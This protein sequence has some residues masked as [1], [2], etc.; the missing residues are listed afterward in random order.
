MWDFA[1]FRARLF[2]Q[3]N[4]T[5]KMLTQHTATSWI[6]SSFFPKATVLRKLDINCSKEIHRQTPKAFL[7][8]I[9]FPKLPLNVI[10]ISIFNKS[11]KDYQKATSLVLRFFVMET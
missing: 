5:E 1:K 2:T 4:T 11:L 3:I 6:A 7:V 8:V 9:K 10:Y